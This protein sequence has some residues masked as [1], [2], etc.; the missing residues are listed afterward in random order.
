[1]ETEGTAQ[2]TNPNPVVRRLVPF[3]VLAIILLLLGTAAYLFFSS[4]AAPLAQLTE[5]EDLN[6][7]TNLYGPFSEELVTKGESSD[8]IDYVVVP[9]SMLEPTVLEAIRSVYEKEGKLIQKSGKLLSTNPNVTGHEGDIYQFQ[10]VQNSAD[11]FDIFAKMRALETALGEGA[12]VSFTYVSADKDQL[13]SARREFSFVGPDGTSFALYVSASEDKRV[14]EESEYELPGVVRD[15]IERTCGYVQDMHLDLQNGLFVVGFEEKTETGAADAVFIQKLR[16][17]KRSGTDWKLVVE[18]TLSMTSGEYNEYGISILADPSRTQ[19]AISNHSIQD[20][21][22]GRSQQSHTIFSSANDTFT[23]IALPEN[24][25]PTFW[26][27]ADQLLYGYAVGKDCGYYPKEYLVTVSTATAQKNERNDAIEGWYGA[28]LYPMGTVHA[29]SDFRLGETTKGSVYSDGG[30]MCTNG[31]K[32]YRLSEI[33]LAGTERVLETAAPGTYLDTYGFV[34]DSSFLYA[35]RNVSESKPDT[36]TPSLSMISKYGTFELKT[37]DAATGEIKTISEEEASA[38]FDPSRKE[39]AHIV[40]KDAY[41][42]VKTLEDGT[43]DLDFS[44]SFLKV[45]NMITDRL[46]SRSDTFAEYQ[47]LGN[48]HASNDA[49]H[50]QFTDW[51]VYLNDRTDK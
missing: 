39:S 3:A 13:V 7:P 33:T 9:T 17:Y 27:N 38:Y 44:T 20:M 31:E 11:D 37:L 48:D 15:C 10:Y 2:V 6:P 34:G 46:D 8:R 40:R 49:Y 14:I 50:N 21:P 32:T 28:Y 19:I 23:D 42:Y 18:K 16:V 41:R 26:I 5:Q 47:R 29:S 22:L 24:L 51:L 35:V 36:Y 1:M 12:F 4:S 30:G 43:I 45:G 25:F